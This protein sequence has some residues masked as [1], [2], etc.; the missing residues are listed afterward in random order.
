M[1]LLLVSQRVFSSQGETIVQQ[2]ALIPVA[3]FEHEK[4]CPPM[5]KLA[6]VTPMLAN[7]IYKHHIYRERVVLKWN[8]DI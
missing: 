3:K 6:Y 1:L 2:K 5:V 8:L 4:T 7:S